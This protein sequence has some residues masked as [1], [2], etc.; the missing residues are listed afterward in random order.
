MIELLWAHSRKLVSDSR[1]YLIFVIYDSEYTYMFGLLDAHIH[2]FNSSNYILHTGTVTL[3]NSYQQATSCRCRYLRMKWSS[4]WRVLAGEYCLLYLQHFVLPSWHE[5]I[6][7]NMNATISQL[8]SAISV[9][10]HAYDF[11]M[12]FPHC[13]CNLR[14]ERTN[15]SNYICFVIEGLQHMSPSPHLVFAALMH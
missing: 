3:A 7:S 11:T 13:L 14:A 1:Y 4:C 8:Q 15:L 10:L 6:N 5:Q 9:L 12:T 2:A